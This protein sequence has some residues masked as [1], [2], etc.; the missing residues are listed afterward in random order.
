MCTETYVTVTFRTHEDTELKLIHSF[1]SYAA[2]KSTGS[3]LGSSLA[4][5][6]I[7]EK[8]KHRYLQKLQVPLRGSI[9]SKFATN[10]LMGA[11]HSKWVQ[12]I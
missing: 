4:F 3:S 10:Y 1:V 6:T 2:L 11:F 12:F 8:R 9:L 7:A 5:G